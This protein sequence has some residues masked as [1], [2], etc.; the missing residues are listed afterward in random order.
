MADHDMK[1]YACGEE[2]IA[3]DPD[4]KCPACYERDVHEGVWKFVEIICGRKNDRFE[5]EQPSG[6]ADCCKDTCPALKQ[7]E[8]VFTLLVEKK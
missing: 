5:C 6:G 8:T 4:E 1:C 3:E 7:L 2:W